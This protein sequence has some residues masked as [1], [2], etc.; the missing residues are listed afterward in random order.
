MSRKAF[1][2]VFFVVMTLV[3]SFCSGLIEAESQDR[4]QNDLYY[5]QRGLDHFNKG[6]HT[7]TPKGK[8]EEAAQE[9]EQAAAEFK[10]A[11][12]LNEKNAQ[13]RLNLA[14]VYYVQKRFSMAAEEYKRVLELM[15]CDID[16][17]VKLASAYDRIKRYPDAIEAL[18]KAK[19]CTDDKIVAERLTDLIGRLETVM[20][21]GCNT[22]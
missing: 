21:E 13:A 10:R 19:A 20:R 16:T 3:F 11:I 18:N 14:R 4:G 9:Y 5:N 7:L 12:A 15:P 2:S 17:F 8:K 6:F 22:R 1:K